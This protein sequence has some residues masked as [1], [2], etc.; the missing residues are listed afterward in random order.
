MFVLGT[1]GH[2]DHGKS[3]LVKAL[4]GIDPDRLP[5]E[6]ERG[7]TIDLG[8][9]WFTLP[10]GG[11]VGIVDV[12]GHERF[13]R[14]MAA[15]AGGINAALLVIAADDGWM[16]QTQE[17]F[18]ILRLLSIPF[19]CVALTKV[20]LVEDDWL[21][22][23]KADISERLAGSFLEEAPII[24]V[25]S[26][27]GSGID[28][29]R[30]A[31]EDIG[32]KISAVADVGKPRLFLDRVFVLTGI[33]VVVTGTSRGGQITAD[34]MLYHFPSTRR[35]RV[36]GL[37]AHG[38]SV[39]GV[40][41]GSRVAIN[42]TGMDRE[43]IQRGDVITGLPYLTSNPYLAVSISNLDESRVALKE[44]RKVV[45]IL[46]TTET[47][48]II[49]PFPNSGIAPGQSGF[50]ILKT[51]KPV[52]AYLGDRFIIRLP[53]PQVTLGG[54]QVL[55]LLAAYPRRKVLPEMQDCLESRS[56]GGVGEFVLT[57]VEKHPF[58][59][60]EKLLLNSCFSEEEIEHAVEAS[61][62]ESAIVRHGRFLMVRAGI[63][64]IQEKLHDRLAGLHREKSYLPGMTVAELRKFLSL[65]TD[66]DTET[67]LNYFV[68]NA[69]LMRSR[70]FYH[71]PGFSPTLDPAMEDEAE[72]I[73][74]FCR[75]RG[76]QY[77]EFDELRKVFPGGEKT[78]KFLR[79]QN[80]LVQI[81]SQFIT[82]PEVWDEIVSV[83]ENTIGKNAALTIADFR[84]KFGSS[85]KYALPVLEHCDAL[86]L[87]RRRGDV[88]VRGPRFDERYSL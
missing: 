21:E 52:C 69:S 16:P 72:K 81:G 50:A 7:L 25:S 88:R 65:P 37:E 46:G 6:K 79:D 55:D 28:E 60:R 71:L 41:P 34:S 9:A 86:G 75:N 78:I 11:E 56:V 57:E 1:A 33:G 66:E 2:I 42:L 5:E 85:R 82:V 24:P 76:H 40:G 77:P 13:V 23:Q 87:T 4:T 26:T 44:G 29:L 74:S 84:D 54:G 63:D 49:R 22:L 19:G 39:P 30:R 17:H 73:V 51:A 14:N 68:E 67:I 20:D 32:T 35:A 31:I 38:K 83:L 8:F 62:A 70:Q 12:P 61:L 45:I 58:L 3:A 48:A 59:P 64:S 43:D 27:T 80:R 53:T 18:D 36:R 47:E 10:G 15:G